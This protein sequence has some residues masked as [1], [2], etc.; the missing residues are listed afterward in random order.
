MMLYD[1]EFRFDVDL[2]TG[3]TRGKIYLVDPMAGPKTQCELDVV[4]T[5]MTPEGDGLASYTGRCK[6][7][8][9]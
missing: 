5:G 1:D 8:T 7:K 2:V 6:V 9:D 4:G 3:E